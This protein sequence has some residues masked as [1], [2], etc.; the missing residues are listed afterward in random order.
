M[1]KHTEDLPAQ[2]ASESDSL[3]SATSDVYISLSTLETDLKSCGVEENFIL[4]SDINLGVRPVVELDRESDAKTS[5]KLSHYYQGRLYGKIEISSRKP[6]AI[7]TEKAISWKAFKSELRFIATHYFHWHSH[8]SII[9]YHGLALL[10]NEDEGY[11][12]YLLSERVEWKLL[13]LLEDKHVRLTQ[14]EKVSIIHDI[15]SGLSFL[16]SR[17]PRAIVHAALDSSSVLLDKR[18]NAKLTNFFHAGC[19]G[20]PFT[21]VSE[22]HKPKK[23]NAEMKLV[24]SLD[25]KSLGYIIKAVDTEHKNREQVH[26]WRNVLEDFYV[27]YDSENG[28]PQNLT[29]SE[30]SRRLADYLEGQ[31]QLS[32]SQ[33]C[34]FN[35]SSSSSSRTHNNDYLKLSLYF[36]SSYLCY[37]TF[38]TLVMLACEGK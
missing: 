14:Q 12:P 25:M 6:I 5:T 36:H 35:N 10:R 1:D 31:Q 15:A 9:Q 13:S 18:Y 20:D 27:L 8:P 38:W 2:T 34:N 33:S 19:E 17:K 29:A 23:Y 30:V 21:V 16:H 32:V 11:I 24:T 26:G 22:S 7:L 37:C 4:T 28:P 3:V